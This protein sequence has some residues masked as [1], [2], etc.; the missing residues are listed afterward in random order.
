[1]GSNPATEICTSMI[2]QADHRGCADVVNPQR[3]R[4]Q[5]RRNVCPSTPNS[6]GHAG[7]KSA[8]SI[9][10]REIGGTLI[11]YRIR[12]R[13]QRVAVGPFDELAAFEMGADAD[14]RDQ[15]CARSR[16]ACGLGLT[17]ECSSAYVLQAGHRSRF[18]AARSV[19]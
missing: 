5:R 4:A 18:G 10:R 11:A 13:Q 12:P 8:I 2:G 14:Q 7:L 17:G 1:M 6:T 3:H 19:A 16:R 9:L 15:T